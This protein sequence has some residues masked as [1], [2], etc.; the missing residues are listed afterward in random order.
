MSVG[1]AVASLTGPVD[2]LNQVNEIATHYYESQM[3]FRRLQPRHFRALTKG[4]ATAEEL[5]Q[6]LGFH[7]EAGHRLMVGLWQAGLLTREGERFANSDAAAYLTS[8]A[9]E[10]GI[11]AGFGRIVQPSMHMKS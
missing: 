5:G 3:F 1:P 2:A 7:E 4:P 10:T 6:R 8:F 11:V 9:P